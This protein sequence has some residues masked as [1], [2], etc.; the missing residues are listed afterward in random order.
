MK[1]RT[2][3]LCVNCESIYEGAGPC[4]D[5][6]SEVFFWVYQA[7]GTALTPKG[8]LMND[9]PRIRGRM[10]TV[11]LPA[12]GGLGGMYGNLPLFPGGSKKSLPHMLERLGHGI[13]RVLTSRSAENPPKAKPAYQ[14]R[15][16][17]EF[18][19]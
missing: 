3:K 17:L 9:K 2:S 8:V 7:L 19:T 1:L 4:P 12:F 13:S 10:N 14:R 16:P 6:A 5:C 18:R 15:S 11:E